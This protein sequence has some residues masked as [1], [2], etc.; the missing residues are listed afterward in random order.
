M[1]SITRGE[2]SHEGCTGRNPSEPTQGDPADRLD[3]GSPGAAHQVFGICSALWSD[4]NRAVSGLRLPWPSATPSG[5]S[6]P[7]GLS[8]VRSVHV[9]P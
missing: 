7:D 8:H 2:R 9:P 6:D 5:I 1:E 3:F 4:P